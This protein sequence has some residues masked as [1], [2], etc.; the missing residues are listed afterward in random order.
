MLKEIECRVTGK[1]QMVLFRDFVQK[2]ARA[3][4]LVGFV[5]NMD[6]GSV[7]IVAQ[8][9]KERLEKLVEYLHKGPFLARV[10]RIDVEWRDSQE[11]FSDFKIL[12]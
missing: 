9:T 7:Q 6:D 3:L 5:E 2:K 12:Y 1:V 8:G 11:Q 10:A 4:E